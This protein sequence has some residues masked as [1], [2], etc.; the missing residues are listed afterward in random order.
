MVT[1]LRKIFKAHVPL[2][3]LHPLDVALVLKAQNG[4]L[5]SSHHI[6]ISG[7]WMEERTKD[8]TKGMCQLS[9]KEGSQELSHDTSGYILLA[10]DSYIATSRS[11]E[12]WKV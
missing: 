9:F 12:G 2:N 3:S 5:S 7:N 6:Q 11:K 10:R 1:L 8:G 4:S